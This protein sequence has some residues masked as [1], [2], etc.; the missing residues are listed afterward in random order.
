MNYQAHYQR[1]V[2]RAKSRILE[3][4]VER[5]HITPKCIG[6]SNDKSNIVLLTPEEH[7]VA[8]QLLVKIYPHVKGLVY[9]CIAMCGKGRTQTRNNKAYGWIRKSQ[10][11]INKGRTSPWKGRKFTEEQ[12]AKMSAN[13]KGKGFHDTAWREAHRAR[14]LGNKYNAGRKWDPTVV[15]K[16]AA[17]NSLAQKGKRLSDSHKEALRLAWVKRK[18]V[19]SGMV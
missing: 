11:L 19:A 4:Y 10:S 6:G 9:A 13:R 2:D 12:L 5:H 16:R 15:A 17:S 7:Y 1:L 14:M 8:H 3:G 18:A